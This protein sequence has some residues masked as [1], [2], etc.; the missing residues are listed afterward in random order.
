MTKSMTGFAA[1]EGSGHGWSWNWDLRAVNGRGLDLRLR[2]PDFP[3]GLEAPLRKALQE[4]AARGNVTLALRIC[5]DAGDEA[6]SLNAEALNQAISLSRAVEA[7]AEAAG[8]ALGPMRAADFLTMRGVLETAR[9]DDAP[10]ALR[11]ALIE[12]AKHLIA[13]F[14]AMRRDEGAALEVVLRDQ[15]TAVSRAVAAARALLEERAA[16]QAEVFRAALSK[17]TEAVTTDAARVAQELALLAVKSD[18][19]EELDRLDA[20]VNAA[21]TLLDGDGP[22]GRKLDFLTQEFNREANTLCAK[23]GFAELTRI[24]LDLKHTI[25]QM[26]EQVQNVE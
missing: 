1:R 21:N 14:D 4:R 17:V 26:R 25:D 2:L 13:A 19:A 15:V 18:I 12:D 20:H 8:M 6:T 10:E 22:K 24:G 9:D 3:D 23:A 5:R 11:A 16:H 7:Q